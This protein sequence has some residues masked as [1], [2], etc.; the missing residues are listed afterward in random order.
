VV[1]VQ[2]IQNTLNNMATKVVLIT[3]GARGIG[4]S[5]AEYMAQAGAGAVVITD[6]LDD[7][8]EELARTLSR[9]YASKILYMHLDVTDEE[10]WAHTV[11]SVVSQTG[12]LDV[13]VNNAG[14]EFASLIED[15]SYAEYKKLM[16][17]NAD[18]VFLGCREAVRAMKPGA[19]AGKG[20]VIIN[21]SSVA[22]IVGAT[23]YTA[24]GGSKGFVRI[25]SKHLAV[26]CGKMG[27]GIRVNSVHP[28]LIETEMGA[29]VF[30]DFVNMGLVETTDDAIAAV[31]QL[32]PLGHIGKV[33]DVAAAVVYLASDAASYVTGVE[34]SID[35]GW[36]AG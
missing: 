18:G 29:K 34:L 11:Q 23:G 35:G 7:T 22:G 10:A 28:G 6:V 25:L 30:D 4:A 12:G 26:E 3:G 21:M 1:G 13:L 31:K 17:V 15:Y 19:A 24:Y 27:Y 16:A 2:S 20:G 36:A 33:E 5:V 8:G 14:I 32:T 9:Q